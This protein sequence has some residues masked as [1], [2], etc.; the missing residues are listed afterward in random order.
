MC[1][2]LIFN[3]INKPFTVIFISIKYTY[4]IFIQ[5]VLEYSDV[6]QLL[7]T[8]DDLLCYIIFSFKVVTMD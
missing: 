2:V 5:K 6:N 4:L 1:K 7:I 3:S 8:D